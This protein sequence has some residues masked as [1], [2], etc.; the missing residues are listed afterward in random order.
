M[1][2]ANS[3]AATADSKDRFQNQVRA[4]L[5][6]VCRP[7]TKENDS[8]RGRT[9]DRPS[10]QMA[11]ETVRTWLFR[12]YMGELVRRRILADRAGSLPMSLAM[13]SMSGSSRWHKSRIWIATAGMLGRSAH[14]ASFSLTPMPMA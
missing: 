9:A 14:F 11:W 8:A 2:V 6:R 5:S 13:A 1:A 4:L 7:L 12:P 3:R 10:R